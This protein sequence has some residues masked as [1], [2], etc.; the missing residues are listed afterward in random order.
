MSSKCLLGTFQLLLVLFHCPACPASLLPGRPFVTVWN[1]PTSRCWDKYGVALD[2]AAFDIVANQNQS[3]MG[4]E[5][6][7][8]YSGQLGLYPYYDKTGEPVNSGLPQNA[9]LK[10]HL[11]QAYE[12]LNAT[13][14]SPDFQGVAVI[15]WEDWRPVW[16]R[17]W[18]SKYIYKQQSQELVRQ[19]HPDWSDKQILEEAKREFEDDARRFMESTLELGRKIRPGGLWGFYGF[20]GCYNY[21]YKN[22]SYNYTGECLQVEVE[23]NNLLRWMWDASRA[24]YP[25]IYL[26][27]ML[28]LSKYVGPFVKHRLK[29]A[30]RVSA[31][32]TEG[33]LPVLP[34]ARIVYT[35]SM[36]FLE[37]EDLAQT[38]GQSAALGATGIILWGNTDYSSSKEACLA[39]KSYIDDTLGMYVVNVTSAATLCSRSVCT[40][41]GRCVRRD[42]SSEA[43]LHLHPDSFTISRNPQGT[44]FLVSGQAT[45]WDVL[46][47]AAHFQC[48]CYP[49]WTGADCSQRTVS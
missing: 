20:P 28:K 26:E 36:D 12:D 44:G 27:S 8:F 18:D 24:L 34:Y 19:Q 43:Q 17:N 23:R 5:M 39:V 48:S 42:A 37:Q 38:I 41:N 30:F 3:F 4:T 1:A 22:S 32:A 29:E 47:M 46:H 35:Y 25:E 49:G 40:G 14:V 2:L 15:D 9:S 6:V 16:D 10:D 33:D 7:I 31:E 45:K 11:Q 13:M 21:G